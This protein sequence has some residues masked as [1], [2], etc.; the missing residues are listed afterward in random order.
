MNKGNIKN[1]IKEYLAEYD[2]KYYEDSSTF[3]YGLISIPFG[4]NF[5]SIYQLSKTN[6]VEIRN[7]LRKIVIRLIKD[8]L[9]IV[10]YQAIKHL[11]SSQNFDDGKLEEIFKDQ[12]WLLDVVAKIDTE[13]IHVPNSNIFKS[14]V[15]EA[16]CNENTE[17]VVYRIGEYA[18]ITD[19]SNT[20]SNFTILN[21]RSLEQ[22]VKEDFLDELKENDHLED[23]WKESELSYDVVWI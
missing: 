11:I 12:Q 5:D 8:N 4:R 10:T 2:L 9:N 19:I 3:G 22:A 17:T 14:K 15:S 18:F 1:I 20:A 13:Y 16:Y 7:S 6:K 23:V 21:G